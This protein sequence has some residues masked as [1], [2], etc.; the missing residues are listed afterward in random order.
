MG[1]GYLKTLEVFGK[2]Q[3]ALC[4]YAMRMKRWDEFPLSMICTGFRLELPWR[5]TPAV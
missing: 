5:N 4:N 1:E 2:E 3:P